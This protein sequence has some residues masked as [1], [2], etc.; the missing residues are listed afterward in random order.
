[1]CT[2]EGWQTAEKRNCTPWLELQPVQLR[3]FSWPATEKTLIFLCS[4][5]LSPLFLLFLLFFLLIYFLVAPSSLCLK[6]HILCPFYKD[7]YSQLTFLFIS[8]VCCCSR[9]AFQII[10]TREGSLLLGL[11]RESVGICTEGKPLVTTFISFSSA[12]NAMPEV[13]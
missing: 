3:S 12:N 8:H 4:L 5:F 1:M 11:C 6:P 2:S 10:N 13:K 7:N 9:F